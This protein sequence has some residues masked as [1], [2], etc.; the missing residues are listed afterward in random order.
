MIFRWRGRNQAWNTPGNW[1]NEDGDAHT[2]DYPGKTASRYD[3]VLFDCAAKANSLVSPAAFAIPEK[4][5]SF[6]VGPDW[7][8]GLGTYAAPVLFRCDSCNIQATSAD[9]LYI[10]GQEK[11]VGGGHDSFNLTVTDGSVYLKH[12]FGNLIALKGDITTDSGI[13]FGSLFIGY[14]ESKSSDVTMNIG[15][16]S[17]TIIRAA[18]NAGYTIMNAFAETIDVYGGT[19]DGFAEC[20]T[21]NVGSGGEYRW[22]NGPISAMRGYADG[23]IDATQSDTPRTVG[24]IW[25]GIGS[26]IDLRNPSQNITVTDFIEHQGGEVLYPYGYKT[27]KY[28]P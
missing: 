11:P 7:D 14:L 6:Y 5:N 12:Y 2:T 16:T 27:M 19:V 15:P 22:K 9:T 23:R 4:L 10:G 28:A 21:L 8:I 24:V 25:A 1:I 26:L 3:D 17:N 20:Y 13:D 18:F